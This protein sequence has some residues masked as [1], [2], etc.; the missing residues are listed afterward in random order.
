M[1]HD[2]DQKL[3]VVQLRHTCD[4]FGGDSGSAIWVAGDDGSYRVA[5]V[6]IGRPLS[7]TSY[8]LATV[9]NAAMRGFVFR[10]VLQDFEDR[11]RWQ[12][13][14]DVC[15]DSMGTLS[16]CRRCAWLHDALAVPGY[17]SCQDG[18]PPC[19]ARVNLCT[20]FDHVPKFCCIIAVDDSNQYFYVLVQHPLCST[21][22]S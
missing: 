13:R 21:N 5:A 18:L 19:F 4:T 15:F 2:A 1:A 16:W 20:S 11:W 9:L 14:P 7:G 10:T 22:P 6:H 17:A 3:A 8:N 12:R